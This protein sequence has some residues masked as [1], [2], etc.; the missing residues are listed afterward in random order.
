MVR[1]TPKQ[2]LSLSLFGVVTI[3]S[4]CFF[5]LL[6]WGYFLVYSV[7]ITAISLIESWRKTK[8]FNWW[9]VPFLLV[10]AAFMFLP[11]AW[12]SE[13]TSTSPSLAQID[14]WKVL[15]NAFLA[16]LGV[17]GQFGIPAILLGWILDRLM[18]WL[19]FLSPFRSVVIAWVLAKLEE[20][21]TSRA[22]TAV[23]AAGQMYNNEL[24][25]YIESNA[26]PN[27]KE[28]QSLVERLKLDRYE[29]A[30][31]Q[32]LNNRVARDPEHAQILIE[33]AVSKLKAQSINP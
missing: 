15:Q 19:P 20:I 21:Q 16:V 7:T 26:Y 27:G 22:Q 32:L 10:L 3:A 13:L 25:D 24:G 11:V 29:R 30:E 14:V 17:L 8:R 23:L 6:P 5:D 31:N 28:F 18:A 9:T 1:T 2:E 12:A 4:L 33:Q